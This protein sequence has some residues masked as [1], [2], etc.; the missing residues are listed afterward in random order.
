MALVSLALVSCGHKVSKQMQGPSQAL[1]TV[2]AQKTVRAAGTKKQV[3]LILPQWASHSTVE[4]SFKAEL[5]KDGVTV[6]FTLLAN[7]G[8][9]MGRNP[10]ALKSTDFFD[11]LHKDADA[12]A[13]VSLAGAPLLNTQDMARL[14]PNH[15]PVL[16]VATRSLGY[17]S[18]GDVLGVPANRNYLT[19]LLDAKV[20]QLAIVD[21]GSEL[22][23]KPGGKTNATQ[24]L[25]FQHYTILRGHD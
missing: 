10:L 16:V 12:G 18:F 2:L 11:A 17:G 15:P 23:A 24:Q 20:V 5:Q 22:N 9:P 7:V 8:D 14:N 4:G 13:I 21:G 3:V 6:A 1:G 25:F 19:S